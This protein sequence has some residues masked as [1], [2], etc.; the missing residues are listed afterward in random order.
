MLNIILDTATNN[1]VMVDHVDFADEI[2]CWKSLSYY[3]CLEWL[4]LN[5]TKH[6]IREDEVEVGM[7]NDEREY[8]LH[9][10]FSYRLYNLMKSDP[11]GL[12]SCIGKYE[13]DCLPD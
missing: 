13:K 5:L 8:N 11:S 1:E 4:K 7:Y 3:A 2:G 6:N 9:L 12:N 10:T